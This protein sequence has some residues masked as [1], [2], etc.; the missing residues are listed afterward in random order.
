MG[1][2]A[3]RRIKEQR[4]SHS[5][6]STY[7]QTQAASTI[8]TADGNETIRKE[9]RAY[10]GDGVLVRSTTEERFDDDDDQAQMITESRFRW[11]TNIGVPEILTID[12][13]STTTDLFYGYGR[14]AAFGKNKLTMFSKDAYGSTISFGN[15]D[16]VVT[17]S[18]YDPWGNPTKADDHDDDDDD[19]DEDRSSA[20]GFGY[21]SE[22]H[23]GNGDI[24]LSA[25]NYD[26]TTGRFTTVDPLDGVVGEL[27]VA[28][29][30]HYANN[31]PL[32]QID[33]LGLRPATDANMNPS[34]SKTSSPKAPKAPTPNAA[35]R[36][37][38]DPKGNAVAVPENWDNMTAREKK[39]FVAYV[40]GPEALNA[41]L[42]PKNNSGILS[43]IKEVF[44][45]P[46]SSFKA[47]IS[48]TPTWFWVVTGAIIL[49]SGGFIA[50]FA[51]GIAPCVTAGNT[52]LIGGQKALDVG[53]RTGGQAIARSERAGALGT[54]AHGAER[55]AGAV[56]TRGGV[57][58]SAEIAVVR[59]GG[60]VYMQ[61]NG[62]IAR[63]LQQADG[64]YSV[65]VDGSRGLI[66]T[67][68]NLSRHSLDQ[69]AKNYGWITP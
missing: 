33:P 59:G 48:K 39:I 69:L 58:N 35:K 64:R 46:I 14:I 23:L 28:N 57:L 53:T 36:V 44:T 51:T 52:V 6:T 2:Q 5:V 19:D 10:D 9:S 26:P 62:A 63:V 22:M 1:G 31:D 67:F 24:Y 7:D 3:D 4:G 54:T 15:D 20:P 29:P 12:S 56:A 27:T 21:R 8:T 41:A 11:D 38:Y 13:G 61:S 34:G 66:T 37:V 65:V 47:G 32:N 17:A 45:N 18:S 30:Y 50:C 49:V 68:Q 43:I 60:T 42:N 25:R 16:R 40:T 55:I